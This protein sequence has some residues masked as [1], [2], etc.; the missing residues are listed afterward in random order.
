MKIAAAF[1][2]EKQLVSHPLYGVGSVKRN[3]FHFLR[4]D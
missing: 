3:N 2:G 1:S 4:F